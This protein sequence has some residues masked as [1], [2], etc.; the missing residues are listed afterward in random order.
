MISKVQ[1]RTLG[2]AAIAALLILSSPS[3]GNALDVFGGS[4]INRTPFDR[5]LQMAGGLHTYLG[6]LSGSLQTSD[7]LF[8]QARSMRYVN[9]PQA[10][11]TWQTP[12]ET[13]TRWSGDCEDKAL[14]LFT[15][16]KQN[17]Y[18]NVRL[19]VGRYTSADN[20]LHVWVTMADNEGHVMILDPTIQKKIWSIEDFRAGYYRPL[21]SFDGINRYRHDE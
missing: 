11:D 1:H 5:Q 19:V 14:W 3:L 18:S 8:M 7:G 10:R 20:A 16:L 12:E 9:D 6:T 2:M 4:L 17:G 13:Q 21:Y 15:N